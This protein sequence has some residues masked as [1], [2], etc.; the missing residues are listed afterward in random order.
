MITDKNQEFQN[1]RE[2]GVEALKT[3]FSKNTS[4]QSSLLLLTSYVNS[5]YIDNAI[6]QQK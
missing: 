5:H 3:I 1:L 6:R 2:N 4:I